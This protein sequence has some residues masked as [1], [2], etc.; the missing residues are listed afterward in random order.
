MKHLKFYCFVLSLIFSL[1]NYAQVV[2]SEILASNKNSIKD[3]FGQSSDWIEL[4]NNST[5]TLN[6]LN[7]TL[8][9]DS[10]QPAKWRFPSVNLEPGAYMIIFASGKNLKESTSWLHTSFSLS[11]AGEYLAL[12]NHAGEFVSG[13]TP[14]FPQQ[15]ED[16]SYGLIDG[17][18][19]YIST[20][21]P[22]AENSRNIYVFPPRFSI[23]R[24]LFSAPFQLS[25][26]CSS[27]GATI[28]YTTDGSSPGLQN[29]I[30]Y[31]TPLTI[32]STS[33]VRAVGIINNS[34][35]ASST[36]TYIFPA[37]VIQQPATPPSYP[38]TW[39][40]GVV[41]DYEMD[42][43]ICNDPK[44]R[45]GI[46][47][48][49]NQL[50]II[51]LVSKPS[52]FFSEVNNDST[53]G[54]YVFTTKD[55]ERA[56]SFEVF[57]SNY[58]DN[59]QIN[60]GVQLQGGN[61]RGPNNSPK[62]SFRLVF[63]PQYGPT[64]MNYRLFPANPES[65]VRF[66]TIHIK[67]GY[68][69]TWYHWNSS[70]R[71]NAQYIRDVWA[72][73]TMR[74][75]GHKGVQ[76]RYAHLFL[77]GLYWGL[78]NFS[79][80]IDSDF[81]ET[82]FGGDE[83][84]YDVIKDYTEIVDGNLNAW[85]EMLAAVRA[86]VENNAEYFRLL[87]KNPDGTDNFA[88]PVYL[89]PV[90]LIDYI[91]LNF[92]GAN[93]D[94][95]QHNWAA[96]RNRVDGRKGFHFFAWDSERIL[97]NAKSNIVTRNNEGYVT[98]IFQRLMKNPEFKLLFADRLHKHLN[99]VG[100]LTP[101]SVIADWEK[102][103][104]EIQLA[105]F[106]ESARW[107]DYRRDVNPSGDPI[108]LYTE[109]FWQTE[110]KRLIEEYFPVRSGILM[111]Q[112]KAAN[113]YPAIEAPRF[114][115]YGGTVTNLFKLEMT[116][117]AGTIF[118]SLTGDPRQTGGS[119]ASDTHTY[120]SPVAFTDNLVT[121]RARAKSGNIW[122]A[123]TEATFSTDI[124]QSLD[125]IYQNSSQLNNYPNPVR[126]FTTIECNLSENSRVQM[127]ILSLQGSVIE[128]IDLGDQISGNFRYRYNASGLKNGVYIYQLQCGKY[129][130]N[131]K[132]TVIK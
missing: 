3:Q 34:I 97:E 127:L 96:G 29:G 21:T 45:T 125:D 132:M 22:G 20:P 69:N 64:K 66:N 76:T 92:Y 42:P 23:E 46:L 33:V 70:Q 111:S 122:S 59:V 26:T 37:Q 2:I 105:V 65:T 78:Y 98:E 5:T 55:W 24:G 62:H 114:N 12:Y 119:I 16:I 35:S 90:N 49:F 67:A 54:I 32:N 73:N 72:K 94:W 113:M 88:Y 39:G 109:E 41:A 106:A 116:A 123:V 8:T 112:F 31:K 17:E 89:E 120:S 110:K 58:G 48:S 19:R 91:I 14:K 38:A 102:F 104:S 82:Y 30:D 7:W 13:M 103:A 108:F 52:N 99:N 60:C 80:R 28:K 51:S 4:Y 11:A 107:G 130:L 83:L 1:Q 25:L 86:G 129:T 115:S 9:D 40:S 6:L 71:R 118:Y 117:A 75:M 61:S 43:E 128:T 100:C 79:E 10:K 85:N 74:K 81:M 101:D 68:N 53:G 63:K 50:P 131:S 57:G 93:Q 126:D 27:V 56:A 44:S 87:G 15:Y 95:D 77:N 84:D 124:A 121:V 36:S 18:Y 47:N